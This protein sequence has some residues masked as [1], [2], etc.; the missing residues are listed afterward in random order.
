MTGSASIRCTTNA[1]SSSCTPCAR[2]RRVRAPAWGLPIVR[3]IVERAGGTVSVRSTL[4]MGSTF[5]VDWPCEQD[6]SVGGIDEDDI[7]LERRAA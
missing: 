2:A 4:G 6:A 3:R 7:S 1:S 5:V